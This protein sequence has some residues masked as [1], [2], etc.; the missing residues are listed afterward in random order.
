MRIR[1][2]LQSDDHGAVLI[3]VGI[4]LLSLLVFAA[5]A[6]DISSVLVERRS[7]QNTADVS[8]LS[9]AQMTLRLAPNAAV[10]ATE[11]EVRRLSL[12][13]FG[14]TSADW[15]GCA[16]SSKP[17]RFTVE[18]LGRHVSPLPPV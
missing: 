16:D 18:G 13:N 1:E 17:A 14:T 11:A 7:A 10:A 8:A 6:V 15:D 4:F 2:R 9:D 12:T 3:T 5:W